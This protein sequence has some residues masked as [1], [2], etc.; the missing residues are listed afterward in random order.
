MSSALRDMVMD[1]TCLLHRDTSLSGSS[2]RSPKPL[3]QEKLVHV[4]L[5]LHN[6]SLAG[7]QKKL[8]NV[9]GLEFLISL[10]E[11]V[12]TLSRSVL[13]I[14]QLLLNQHCSLRK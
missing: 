6:N 9:S 3:A 5:V 8:L 7:E 1:L 2:R 13:Y 12:T 14:Q 11:Q 4:D 10:H